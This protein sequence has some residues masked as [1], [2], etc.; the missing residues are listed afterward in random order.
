MGRLI[1]KRVDEKRRNWLTRTWYALLWRAEQPNVRLLL[2]EAIGSSHVGQSWLYVSDG[3][4]YDNL[5][6][7]EAFRRGAT[8]VYAF[9][10]SG[11]SV[12]TWNTLGQALSLARSDCGVEVDIDPKEM[13][14]DGTLA[15]PWVKGTFTYTWDEP[16]RPPREGTLYLCKLGVWADAPW[17]VRA[18]AMRHPTFPTDSTL[19]QLYDDEE[20]EAY[21]A[22][23]QAAAHTMLAAQSDERRGDVI[24]TDEV[25]AYR[26][27]AGDILL[28]ETVTIAEEP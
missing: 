10:A 22:L 13:V 2:E 21:R 12:T 1:E 14:E 3:G 25:V 23:G 26:T 5:G 6:L 11:D 24:A 19:Q 4:H 7:V 27:D 8:T 20:F 18:Y 15:R 28:E 9:D 17:D 16:N